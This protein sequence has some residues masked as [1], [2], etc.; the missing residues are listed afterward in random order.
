M[1]RRNN[2]KNHIPVVMRILKKESGKFK[3][4]IVTEVAN[5]TRSPYQVLIG[6]ILSLRTKDETTAKASKRLFSLA[7]T[8]KQMTQL[9]TRRIQKAIYPVGFYKT[10]AKTIKE[11]SRTLLK[12]HA[13]KVP[14]DIQTLLTF[15][16]VGRKTANIVLVYGFGKKAIPVDVHVH[17]VANR[18]GWIKTKDPDKTE[19]ELVKIVPKTYWLDLNDIFVQFGQNICITMKPRCEI[20][21]ISKYCEYYKTKFR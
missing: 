14:N 4:P 8:P 7:K 9:T 5:K 2:I 12:E 11:I 18:L 15:K 10:K 3:N 21:P 19:H 1:Y 6:C 17:V 16:G 20:C 13:G